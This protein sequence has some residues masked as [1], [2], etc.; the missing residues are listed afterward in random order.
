METALQ[1]KVEESRSEL[2]QL[3]SFKL[4]QEEYGV[5]VLK[6]R[7]I[8]RMPSIT[9]VPNTP[10][11]IEG[12]INLRGKVIPIIS[13]RK[14]FSLPEGETNS[15]TRIMVIDMEGELMGFVVD[16]V[17]EVIRISESEIQPPPAVVNSAVEQ[18]CL[19]GV[20][21]QTDRLLFFLNL[22]KLI[23]RDERSLFS[24]MM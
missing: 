23:S 3:V 22:E 15:Q 4:E 2:I 9:R 24:G 17:S 5:N 10:H 6:V 14:R 20:I 11:Y 12:V 16:A 13:M 8:I 7:E 1:T 19:A 21:N 18:E